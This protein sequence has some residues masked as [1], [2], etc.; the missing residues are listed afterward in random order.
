[1]S[2][3]IQLQLFDHFKLGLTIRS[4]FLLIFRLWSVS[5]YN[6]FSLKGLELYSISAG[7]NSRIDHLFGKFDTAVVIY[8]CFDDY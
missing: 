1:M 7:L 4:C 5:A 6:L 2:R 8:A 3:R